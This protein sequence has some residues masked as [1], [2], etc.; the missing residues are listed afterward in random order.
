M[1]TS[2]H[3]PQP[4]AVTEAFQGPCPQ[5]CLCRV[6]IWFCA[7]FTCCFHPPSSYYCLPWFPERQKAAFP[8]TPLSC[9]CG[10]VTEPHCP[11]CQGPPPQNPAGDLCSVCTR[12]WG[13]WW[14]LQLTAKAYEFL[15]HFNSPSPISQQSPEQVGAR[16]THPMQSRNHV[17]HLT[18]PKLN[19]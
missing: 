19:H 9:A 10:P 1:V 3:C 2:S 17:G 11:P 6:P 15:W 8:P 16:A 12:G 5:S 7:A 4:P 14:A 13:L 18:L